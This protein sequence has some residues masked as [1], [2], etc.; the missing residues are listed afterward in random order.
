M[1]YAYPNFSEYISHKPPRDTQRW[2]ETF[3]A[4]RVR[5]NYG[6][7]FQ[8]AFAAITRDWEEDDRLDFSYWIKF[9]EERN[10]MKYKTAQ[11]S[12]SASNKTAQYGYNGYYLPI[13]PTVPDPIPAPSSPVPVSN[14]T[15]Q[16]KDQNAVSE[17]DRKR[18]IEMHRK[19][20]I[21]RLHSARKLLTDDNG[22]AVAGEKWE[23]LLDALNDLEKQFHQVN[24]KSES[25]EIYQDMIFRSA[26]L[27]KRDGFVRSYDFL[28]K[29]AQGLPGHGDLSSDPYT[30]GT[31]GGELGNIGPNLFADDGNEDD[32]E[33]DEANK[34]IFSEP[35]TWETERSGGITFMFCPKCGG[36][37][38]DHT[39]QPGDRG[40]HASARIHTRQCKMNQD[41]NDATTPLVTPAVT[42]AVTPGPPLPPGSPGSPPDEG[43]GGSDKGMKEFLNGLNGLGPDD[44]SESDDENVEIDDVK[45][46]T[47]EVD[48]F[49]DTQDEYLGI[50]N[51]GYRVFALPSNSMETR[52]Q[53]APVGPPRPANPGLR[54]MPGAGPDPAPEAKPKL[55]P[56]PEMERPNAKPRI[57]G[58]EPMDIEVSEKEAPPSDT[59]DFDALIDAAFATL[60]VG[61][62]VKQLDDLSR[63]FKNR[64][65]A[66][67][68]SIVDMMMDKLGLSSFFPSLAEATR[69]ALESNQYCLTRIEEVRSKL[70]GALDGK[71]Q[72]LHDMGQQHSIRNQPDETELKVDE[73][74][75]EPGLEGVKQRLGDQ[76]QKEKLRK[77]MRKNVEQSNLLNQVE[78]RTSKG[79]EKPEVEPIEGELGPITKK[80]EKPALP[81]A[82]T[83]GGPMAPS[84]K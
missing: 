41:D 7:P 27:L 51:H 19:K 47:L 20:I 38:I 26:N 25:S 56:K 40:R 1:K 8:H 36:R 11:E 74:P 57:P 60:K 48:D 77:E 28:I 61:D 21:G 55:V 37:V 84:A 80:V 43:A 46:D 39:G 42:P 34:P 23:R 52:A 4:I 31:H 30:S 78:N 33:A 58:K 17:E 9:Y 67:R 66:R 72:S 14:D 82:V 50:D 6:V 73:E 71:G 12:D 44:D 59:K 3:R 5:C 64:E 62:I 18:K 76:M 24:K 65:I 69:S 53:V 63:I 13:R 2:M 45:A 68:L 32:D 83:P 81:P 22:K 70:G 79:K 75:V 10:H 16:A 49:M 54:S 29:V 35:S 15:M